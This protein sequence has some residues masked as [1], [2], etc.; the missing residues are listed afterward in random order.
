MFKIFLDVYYLMAR[1]LAD[2]FNS[3]WEKF[4]ERRRSFSAIEAESFDSR[5][6]KCTRTL[7]RV[8]ES[9]NKLPN[10]VGTGVSLKFKNGKLYEQPCIVIRVT[11]KIP[12]LKD[13]AVPL[14]IDG[15][16]T[17]VIEIGPM[18]PCSAFV[19]PACPLRPG[20]TIGNPKSNTF[21][22]IGCLVRKR[23]SGSKIDESPFS[24]I[25]LLSNNHVLANYNKAKKNDT[26][27]HPGPP[28][29]QPLSPSLKSAELFQWIELEEAPFVNVVDAALAKPIVPVSPDFQGF[30]YIPTALGVAT[31][32]MRVY[33]AG[34]QSGPQR[35]TI[36]DL[37]AS[38]P[39]PVYGPL[40]NVTFYPCIVTNDISNP[41]DSGSVLLNDN[42]EALGLLFGKG[43]AGSSGQ[44]PATFYNY[45]GR[46][47]HELDVDLVL[48]SNWPSHPIV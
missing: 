36:I 5:I 30:N 42:H 14:E 34:A 8:R 13:G 21:G 7:D 16:P 46:A 4:S 38:V 15:W 41:G 19:E 28:L 1:T 40:E 2:D 3:E 18:E 6:R 9:L 17:D 48:E 12:N 37:A 43:R 10:V 39:F 33:I 45:L 44:I 31:M 25:M 22:T 47:L 29:N 20:N 27:Q 26:L 11:K 23:K 32:G 24:D 35:G